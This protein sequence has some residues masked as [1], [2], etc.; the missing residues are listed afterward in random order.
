MEYSSSKA[1]V[2]RRTSQEYVKLRVHSR[3]NRARLLPALAELF[4]N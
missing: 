1:V 2:A 4:D 3:L